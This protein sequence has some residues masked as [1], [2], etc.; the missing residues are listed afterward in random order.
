MNTL[1]N[2]EAVKRVL[3]SLIVILVSSIIG[4][5]S[6]KF[7]AS[8]PAF[9]ASYAGDTMWALAF[10]ALFRL[11]CYKLKLSVIFMITLD[12]SFL[13]ELSQLLHNSFL[14]DIRQT[15]VGCL[16]LGFGFKWS[17]LVCYF[18]GCLIGWLIFSLT[19]RQASFSS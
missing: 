8:L 14:A 3:I 5:G 15:M 16:I 11:V 19:L 13:I 2:K 18:S 6:R 1:K 12:F 9:V 10:F 4:L 17:D 7:S